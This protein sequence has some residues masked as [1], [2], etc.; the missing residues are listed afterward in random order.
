MSLQKKARD[1]ELLSLARQH[2]KNFSR[3]YRLQRKGLYEQSD[4]LF[5]PLLEQQEKQT[6]A[7]KALRK[8]PR[9]VSVVGLKPNLPIEF[10]T[11]NTGTKPLSKTWM[12]KQNANGDFFL[13]DCLL[14]I[15]DSNIRLANSN[16]S[17]PF[18]IT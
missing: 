13:N 7:I 15:K 5:K 6:E 14:I 18:T 12:F 17:Y 3:D 10:K 9:H 4:D 11:N 16:S 1:L 8:A 2:Q